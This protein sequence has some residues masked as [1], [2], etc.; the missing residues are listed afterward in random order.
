MTR[1]NEKSKRLVQAFWDS[2]ACGE[3]YGSDQERIRYELEPLIPQ[4]ADFSSAR[5]CR[6]LEVGVGMGADFLQ[7]VR[8]GAEATGIDLTERGVKITSQRLAAEGLA[9]QLCAADAELLPFRDKSFDLIYS[10]GVLHHTPDTATALSEI[11]R[12]LRSGG[13]LKVMIYHRRSWMALAAWAWFGLL[14][15]RPFMTLRRAVTFVES[16]G[17]KAFTAAEVRRMLGGF[18]DVA[19]R[20]TL[21]HWDRKRAPGIASLFGDRFGWFLLVDAIKG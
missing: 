8:N 7:W 21:T 1:V 15:G 3:R 14:R 18:D 4:F 11:R 17:T 5:G 16:P 9:G 6:V 20:P 12:V 13:R 10:Y 2:E 19:I